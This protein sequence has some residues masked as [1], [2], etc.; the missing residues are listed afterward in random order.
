MGIIA[1]AQIVAKHVQ[2]SLGNHPP[3]SRGFRQPGA[4]HELEEF[5]VCDI[6]YLQQQKY[7]GLEL[8]ITQSCLPGLREAVVHYC[9]IKRL[10]DPTKPNTGEVN[11]YDIQTA[12]ATA[13][14]RFLENAV[15]A[16]LTRRREGYEWRYRDIAK[17]Y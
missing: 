6:P 13:C 5:T 7:E 17:L 15:E 9:H 2:G 12:K 8:V 10:E 4:I 16:I 11:E 1:G 14:R 3:V